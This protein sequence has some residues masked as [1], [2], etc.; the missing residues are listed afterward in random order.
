MNDA[1]GMAYADDV[2][3]AWAA[4]PLGSVFGMSGFVTDY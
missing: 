4:T 2:M 3:E 1:D